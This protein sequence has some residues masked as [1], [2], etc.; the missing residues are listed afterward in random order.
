M[1]AINPRFKKRLI[2]DVYT[3]HPTMTEE[4]FE[5]LVLD[6]SLMAEELLNKNFKLRWHLKESKE[7]AE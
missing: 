4:E 6:Q 2:L 7:E 5:L 3:A 1:C